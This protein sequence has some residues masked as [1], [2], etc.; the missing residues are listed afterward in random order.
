M[1]LC[2]NLP[3]T[4]RVS[5]AGVCGRG[6]GAKGGHFPAS[7]RGTGHRGAQRPPA[8]HAPSAGRPVL[9]SLHAGIGAALF[10]PW[11]GWVCVWTSG[12]L[13]VLAATNAAVYVSKFTRFAGEVFGLLITVRGGGGGAGFRAWGCTWRWVRSAARPVQSLWCA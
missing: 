8:L 7:A 4:E 13:L 3:G 6:E 2:I 9:E 10:L 12:F 1:T 5:V 11:A